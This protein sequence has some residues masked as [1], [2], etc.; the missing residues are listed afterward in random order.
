MTT[1]LVA[2]TRRF[3]GRA[4]RVPGGGELLDPGMAP[5]NRWR[6]DPDEPVF[7]RDIPAIASLTRKP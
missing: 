5:L 7:D 1:D 4:V 2:R 6:P 3:L